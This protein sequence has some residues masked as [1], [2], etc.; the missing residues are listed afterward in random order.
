MPSCGALRSFRSFEGA[1]AGTGDS[2]RWY[3]VYRDKA[4]EPAGVARDEGHAAQPDLGG[5]RDSRAGAEY[6]RE[7]ADDIA[8]PGPA[9]RVAGVREPPDAA[10]PGRRESLAST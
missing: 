4:V 10:P 5:R 8:S 3:V 6:G 2:T 1:P 7:M 9:T